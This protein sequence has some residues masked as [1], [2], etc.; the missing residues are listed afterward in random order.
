M[1]AE[2][3]QILTQNGVRPSKQAGQPHGASAEA[4]IT[5][6]VQLLQA[7]NKAKV[8][9]VIGRRIGGAYQSERSDNAHKRKH[10]KHPVSL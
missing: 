9:T 4:G 10:Q 1:V 8:C 6:A 2:P 5:E 3:T 7:T